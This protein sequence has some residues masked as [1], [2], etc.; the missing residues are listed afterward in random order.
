MRASAAS[1]CDRSRGDT[2]FID[3]IDYRYTVISTRRRR[4]VRVA[5]DVANVPGGLARA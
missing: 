2:K 3:L 4:R 5:F 1:A